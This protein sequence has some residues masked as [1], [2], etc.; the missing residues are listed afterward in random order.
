MN[1]FYRYFVVS[2][3]KLYDSYT[4]GQFLIEGFHSPFRFNRIGNGGG[5]MLYVQ[6]DI[7]AKLL[8]HDFPSA[9]SSFIEIKLYKKK[10]LINCSYNPHCSNIGKHIDIM[11]RSVDT[12]STKY[13]NI[14]LLTPC[15]DDDDD[16]DDDDFDDFDDVALL[17]F[18][19]SY[20]LHNLIKQATCFKNHENPSCIDLILTNKP[21]SVQT[22][23]AIETGFL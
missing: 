16:D 18:C 11:S 13:E 17:T 1:R 14:V 22:K 5:I 8:S 3:T 20:F 7:P 10:W 21:H 23:F 2:E 12:L 4:E 9:E 15:D 19:K 6:K